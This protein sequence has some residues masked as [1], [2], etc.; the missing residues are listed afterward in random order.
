MSLT[1]RQAETKEDRQEVFRFRYEIYV[2]EM[3]KPMPGA[4]H[5]RWQL[6]DESDERATHLMALDNQE[7]VGSLRII[8]GSLEIPQTYP[9]WYGLGEFTE[10]P[11]SALSFT[12]RLM[13]LP[14]RRNSLAA[15]ALA[16]EAFRLGLK[17][18]VKFDFIHTT[19][20][21]V[22]FF[23][24]LGHRRYRADFVDPDLGP[25]IPMVLALDDREHLKRCRSPLQ[26]PA[27]AI[28]PE[29][30][31]SSWF[32]THFAHFNPAEVLA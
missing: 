11:A 26:R 8:W 13:V 27:G 1:I 21:L 3:G 10:F 12:G 28:H 22:R 7:L 20:P 5:S 31:T 2:K 14:G 15:T 25:R 4:D 6:Y 17:R 30:S 19:P 29:G 18:G 32:A 23:E 16:G 9:G 24:R